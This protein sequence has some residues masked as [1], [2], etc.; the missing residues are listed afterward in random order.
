MTNWSRLHGQL[1]LL[2]GLIYVSR[3]DKWTGQTLTGHGAQVWGYEGLGTEGLE[4]V[5][6]GLRLPSLCCGVALWGLWVEKSSR[7]NLKKLLVLG[8]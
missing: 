8:T 2:S 5:L 7:E 4:C 3:G 1:G 6:G